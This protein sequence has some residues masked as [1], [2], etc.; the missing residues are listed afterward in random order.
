MKMSQFISITLVIILGM[1]L[2]TCGQMTSNDEGMASKS[3]EEASGATDDTTTTTFTVSS[4]SPTDGQTSVSRTP[5]IIITFSDDIYT[6]YSAWTSTATVTGSCSSSSFNW[7][8]VHVSSDNFSQCV[9]DNGTVSGKTITLNLNGILSASTT[10][11]I[12]IMKTSSDG[13]WTTQSTS[14]TQ[15]SSD[16]TY[17]FTTQ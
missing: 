15:L 12:K 13:T 10:Y 1:F 5:D 16:Y 3:I 9:V 14:G 11:K 8:V 17:S 7:K 2:N 4:V 6:G